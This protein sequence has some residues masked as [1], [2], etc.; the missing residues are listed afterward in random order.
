[1]F[2]GL[3]CASRM[4]FCMCL[5]EF[6]CVSMYACIKEG[7]MITKEGAFMCFSMRM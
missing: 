3:S 7:N 1:M 2:P 6:V 5:C 4:N